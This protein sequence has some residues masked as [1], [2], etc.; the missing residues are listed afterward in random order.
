MSATKARNGCMVTLN[1][2]S[3]NNRMNA[4]IASG[5]KANSNGALGIKASASAETTAPPRMNGMRRPQRVQVP[6]EN[7]PTM[8]WMTSPATG[9]ASQK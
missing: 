2:K 9:A 6:S 1:D 8:G 4:P 3:M 7:N 5:A